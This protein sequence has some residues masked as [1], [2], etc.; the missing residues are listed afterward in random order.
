MSA[1]F[2]PKQFNK[3][4]ALTGKHPSSNTES[5]LQKLRKLNLQSELK[6]ISGSKTSSKKLLSRPSSGT[7][8]TIRAQERDFDNPRALTQLIG[9]RNTSSGRKSNAYSHVHFETSQSNQ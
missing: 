2:H 9:N 4:K 1:K 5:R 8:G 3:P 6:A 7:D